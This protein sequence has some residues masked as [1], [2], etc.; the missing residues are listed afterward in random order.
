ME[1]KKIIPEREVE[2]MIFNLFSN[3]LGPAFEV[4]REYR[5]KGNRLQDIAILHNREVL[6][7]IECKRDANEFV[8]SFRARLWLES[9]FMNEIAKY[10]FVADKRDC[11]VFLK[12]EF[13]Y[14]KITIDEAISMIAAVQNATQQPPTH[15]EIRLILIDKAKEHKLVKK[16]RPFADSLKEED[17]IIDKDSSTFSFPAN[18][19]DDLFLILLERVTG[20]KLCRFTTIESLYELLKNEKQNM[21]NIVCM[22]D[23]GEYH[24]A[25]NYVYDRYA[26]IGTKDFNELD[27]CFILSLLDKSQE[28]N[29]TMWRLYGDNAKGACITYEASRSILSG[30][31]K[32]FFLAKVSYAQKNKVHPKLEFIK[33][34]LQ[35]F[36]KRGWKLSLK[37]WNIWKH[38]FKSHLFAVEKE[39]RLMYY[40]A[41]LSRTNNKD[42]KWIKNPASQI[43]SKMQLFDF[44]DIPI[45]VEYAKVGPNCQEAKLL[46]RQFEVM[47]RS[48]SSLS[49]VSVDYSRIEDYR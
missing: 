16:I 44:K 14:T 28:D 29:L 6:A 7:F 1:E 46:A 32:Q 47:A 21:C 25:D 8:E 2:R 48:K 5:D 34:L 45:K 22:N 24:Y 23:R 39:V 42:Y 9:L 49:K 41:P 40:D 33:S 30:I 19:E 13:A 36:K 18:I 37:R 15:S 35:A 31:N 43:V 26:Q 17:I 27:N 11:Y 38:F 10:Y 4:V 12:N 3:K 20:S